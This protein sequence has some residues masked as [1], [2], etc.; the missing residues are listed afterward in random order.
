MP[1]KPWGGRFNRETDPGVERFTSS[2]TFDCRLA[3]ED[4]EG[5]LAHAKALAT[6]GIIS[7]E[8]ADTI[9]KGLKEV[10]EE[11]LSPDFVPD[12][13]Y[14]DIHMY[15]ETRLREKVGPV[16]GKLH[17]GRSRN[18]QIALDMHLYLLREVPRIDELLRHLQEAILEKASAYMDVVMPGYTH[19]QRAQPVLFSHHLLAYF[20]MLQR[21]RE[22]LG[23]VCQRADM[24][25]LGAGALAG[26]GFELDRE[27]VARR[28]GFTRLYENSMDAVSDRDF[29][30]EFLSFASIA[31]MHLSRLGEEIINWS[32]AEFGFMELDDA[33]AT[34]SSLMPQKKNP[35]IAELTRGKSGRVYGEL[36]S[37]LTTMKGLPLCYN[38]DLQEDKEGVFDAIDTLKPA[39]KLCGEMLATA[40]INGDKMEEAIA[41]EFAMATDVADYLVLQG[42]PFRDAHHLVGRLVGYCR[43]KEVSP[44]ELSQEELSGFHSSLHREK[45]RELLKPRNSVE[46][47]VIR[48]GTAT[49]AVQDQLN[50]AYQQMQEINLNPGHISG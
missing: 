45:F 24:M 2:I 4:I 37:L 49:S 19:L 15:I 23:G 26:S 38:R 1:E 3:A 10:R 41:D 36:V 25:P 11:V 6:A 40:G 17:T 21:D 39:L 27:E 8:E 34:G 20:W 9:A 14:E 12:P 13:A 7:R 31:M 48:G 47:R 43:Q 33:Y 29:L 5:S 35:D 42:V 30:L 28:L 18:D 44:S 16:G 46:T 22:R 50:R 32:S